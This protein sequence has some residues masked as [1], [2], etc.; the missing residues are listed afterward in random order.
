MA[1]L[2]MHPIACAQ[3]MTGTLRRPE[4]C[5]RR[6]RLDDLIRQSF[7]ERKP[8]GVVRLSDAGKC[9]VLE[10]DPEAFN[11]VL[12]YPLLGDVLQVLL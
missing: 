7:L 8:G 10:L 5:G 6:K 2:D 12:W 3:N 11:R 1:D 4:R 9:G